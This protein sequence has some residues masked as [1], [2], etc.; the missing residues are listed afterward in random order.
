MSKGPQHLGFGHMRTPGIL[1]GDIIDYT[2][3]D[4]GYVHTGEEKCQN[5][6]PLIVNR[7]NKMNK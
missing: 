2:E 4:V 6:E 7:F 1:C 3:S 5:P